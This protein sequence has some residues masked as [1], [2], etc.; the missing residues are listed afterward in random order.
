M[1]DTATLMTGRVE[2]RLYLSV[3]DHPSHLT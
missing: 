2:P 1:T 3:G